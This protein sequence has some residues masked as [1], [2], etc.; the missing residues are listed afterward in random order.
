MNN[1]I[2]VIGELMNNSY[3]RARKAWNNRDV[4]GYQHLAKLQSDLGASYLT[5]NTDG[6]QKLSVKLEE[7]IDFLPTPWVF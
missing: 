4:E 7:M 1:K 6:T 2:T 3:G 5:L